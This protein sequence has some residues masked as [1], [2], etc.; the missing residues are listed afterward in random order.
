MTA[1]IL[2]LATLTGLVLVCATAAWAMHFV[3]DGLCG[4]MV[5]AQDVMNVR[6]SSKDAQDAAL[7]LVQDLVIG[8]EDGEDAQLFGRITDITVD[9]NGTMYVV[10]A[11]FER[12]QKYSKSGV[13]LGTIGRRGEGPGEYYA[14]FA[15][16]T[17]DAGYV[18]VTGQGKISIFDS[19]G[20]FVDEFRHGLSNLI[21]KI[22]VDGSGR[23]F[24][25]ALDLLTQDVVHAYESDGAK[26]FSF[27]KSFAAGTDVDTRIE[28]VTGGGYIDLAKD[29]MIYYTQMTPY[30]I[31]KYSP[32]G[33]LLLTV[34]RA[35]DFMRPI[36][37][38]Y[39]TGDGMTFHRFTNSISIVLLPSGR[40]LNVVMIPT[41]ASAW[42]TVVDAFEASG[43][44]L[45]TGR[46]PRGINIRCSDEKGQVYAAEREGFPKIVRYRLS[47]AQE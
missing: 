47:L 4:L 1:R 40:F 45:A 23:V 3:A 8:R 20:R 7:R 39:L 33:K 5:A 18:Y 15:V 25:S 26:L 21:R 30:E 22:R 6:N 2:L 16:A 29:G 14:P 46:Y 27:C 24:L 13:F 36:E 38:E 32:D 41:G 12:V 37:V 31:R 42:E 35:N 10:D 43:F 44:L 34:S 19:D 28:Q 17:D 11:G 9:L